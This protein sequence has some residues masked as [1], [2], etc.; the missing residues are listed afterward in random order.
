MSPTI[1]G[2]LLNCDPTTIVLSIDGQPVISKDLG[3]LPTPDPNSPRIRVTYRALLTPGRHIIRLSAK[4]ALNIERSA[5]AAILVQPRVQPAGVRMFSI[6]F[7][8]AEG[9]SDPEYVFGGFD[10]RLARWIPGDLPGYA[11]YD[12]SIFPQDSR[13]TFKPTD[14]DN[15]AA[16]RGIGYWVMLPIETQINV[17]GD[18]D[19]STSYSIKLQPGWNMIGNPFDFAVDWN[20]VLVQYAGETVSVAKAAASPRNWLRQTLYR[21]DGTKY[22][23]ANPPNGQLM[24]WEGHWVKALVPCTLVIPPLQSG[25]Q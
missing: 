2:S 9:S 18:L 14:V 16:P 25:A 22:Q 23:W 19:D 7:A 12:P 24:P 3:N 1:R 11:I 4:N 15:P 21:F 20:S 17:L 10:F 8:L 6:P 13:A 5:Q